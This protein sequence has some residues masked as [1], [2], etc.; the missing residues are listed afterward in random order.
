MQWIAI[1]KEP[2]T[3]LLKFNS[4]E[5]VTT[6]L[7]MPEKIS[8]PELL[9]LMPASWVTNYE[10]HMEIQKTVKSTDPR[11]IKNRDGSVTIKFDH[12]ETEA[13]PPPAFSTQFMMQP[14]P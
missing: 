8:R 12:D 2:E 10:K 5:G 11:L 3:L 4:H 6:C 14:C 13:P 9:K 7:H 1:P